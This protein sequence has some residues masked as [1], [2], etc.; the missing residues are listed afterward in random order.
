MIKTACNKCSQSTTKACCICGV[1]ICTDCISDVTDKN[2]KDY[3]FPCSDE[4][5]MISNGVAI[6]FSEPFETYLIDENSHR[7]DNPV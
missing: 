4:H 2:R 3:C 6:G 1:S 7:I 5:L